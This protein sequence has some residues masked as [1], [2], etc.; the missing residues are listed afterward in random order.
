MSSIS[1]TSP[2]SANTYIQPV[3]PAV[4]TP[5]QPATTQVNSTEGDSDGDHDGSKG[6]TIDTHA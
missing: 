4:V 1:A 2:V 5:Q 3:K 6:G